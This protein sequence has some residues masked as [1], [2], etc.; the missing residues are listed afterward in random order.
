VRSAERELDWETAP[1]SLTV[2]EAAALL[3]IPRNAAYEAVRL[4]L[5]PAVNL[6]KR[7]M[8]IS[9]VALRK[10]FEASSGQTAATAAFNHLPGGA[11]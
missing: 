5:L 7:R 11:K 9:K 6:G 10:V 8:R 3:R 4:G 2:R 1:D